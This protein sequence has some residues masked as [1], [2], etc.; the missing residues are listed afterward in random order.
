MTC[1]GGDIVADRAASTSQELTRLS[2]GE[3]LARQGV[4]QNDG[5]THYTL[6]CPD[7]HCGACIGRIE[8]GL[9]GGVGVK[10]AR[11]NL[12]LKRVALKLDER[13][14]S[15]LS[16][17]DE[18]ERLGY[19][20]MPLEGSP[21][22]MAKAAS[23]ELLKALAVAGFAAMNV[24]LLSVS[25]WSGADGSTR[26]LFHLI[27]ALIAIPAVAYSGRIFFRSAL[28]ALKNGH[29]N[30]DVPISLAVILATGMS[31]YE[32][33][34]HGQEAYFDAAVSLLFFLLIGRYLDQLMRERARN[35]VLGMSHLSVKGA[36]VIEKDG[37]TTYHSIDEVEAGQRLRILPGE[38]IPVDGVIEQGVSDLD[39]SLV[40]GENQPTTL[41]EGA[42][43][44]AGTFNL[45]GVLEIR[46]TQS[47][48]KSFL[49]EVSQML[50]AAERGRGQY[51]RTADRMAQIYAPAVH[52]LAA[53]AFVYWMI[54]GSDWHASLYVAISVLIITCPCALGLA[55][56]VV[57][58]VAASRLF[59]EGILVKDG[60]AL[61]R[62]AEIDHAVFDKTGTL[63]TPLPAVKSAK[64]DN[65]FQAR[66]ALSLST[67]S[68][69]P[70]SRALHEHLRDCHPLPLQDIN[71][72]AG[73]GVEAFHMGQQIRLGSPSFVG[74]IASTMPQNL[75]Q[76]EN[77][78]ILFAIKGKRAAVIE[79]SET[80][81]PGAK[82]MIDS[83]A[84]QGM[85]CEI[86]SG[87]KSG[88]V[89][90][91]AQKARHQHLPL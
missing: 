57:H 16:I 82:E 32:T 35:A 55:V 11:V 29:L 37:S 28:K 27:S 86:L 68:S 2:R 48:E 60:S 84:N 72:L 65:Q 66:L 54:A 1:C 77:S 67:L 63:T 58:V 62:M 38:R 75:S 15:I 25:A 18:L 44:S 53:L 14:A 31:L 26:D 47:A 46:A 49:A 45:T 13:K 22:D 79:I 42:K 87:D 70:A 20:A 34:N 80:V 40:T 56:P 5:T 9:K 81:R 36:N 85:D 19:Q 83:L 7:I 23:A 39:V 6:S 89:S 17:V 52:L 3:A 69:H 61:E 76:T 59:E 91:L 12:T 43:V 64:F 74:E 33:L 24:M 21:E 88:P 10:E 78:Q 41:G 8:R 50:G 4:A 73:S 30:M 51:V 71:E 90:A